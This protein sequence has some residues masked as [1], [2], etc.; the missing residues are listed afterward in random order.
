MDEQAQVKA[1]AAEWYE[2][3]FGSRMRDGYTAKVALA[4]WQAAHA[5][6]AQQAPQPVVPEGFIDAEK[7][8]M[9]GI[10]PEDAQDLVFKIAEAQALLSAGKGGEV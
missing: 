5:K 4:C 7:I 3:E 6:Y 1:H 10:T 9:H 8:L 2:K